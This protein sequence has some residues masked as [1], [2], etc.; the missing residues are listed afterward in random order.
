MMNATV[1]GLAP[2]DLEL[3]A[4][5]DENTGTPD[6]RA[7]VVAAR[8]LIAQQGAMMPRGTRSTLLSPRVHAEMAGEHIAPARFIRERCEAA[9][10]EP[11]PDGDGK[12]EEQHVLD[13]PPGR[14][15]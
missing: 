2:R 6:E 7:A 1:T 13:T 8:A 9:G 14:P 10:Y 11:D 3:I 5:G 4:Q 15:A 12:D